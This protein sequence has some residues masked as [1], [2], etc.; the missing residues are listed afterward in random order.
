MENLKRIKNVNIIIILLYASLYLFNNYTNI[1]F[2]AYTFNYYS[3]FALLII[4]ILSF[5]INGENIKRWE[6][7]EYIPAIIALIGYIK[8]FDL[9]PIFPNNIMW[10]LSQIIGILGILFMSKYI[11]YLR[12]DD[13]NNSL[14]IQKNLSLLILTLAS[15]VHLFYILLFISNPNEMLYKNI[16]KFMCSI[17]LLYLLIVK[18]QLKNVYAIP[19]ALIIPCVLS[20]VIKRSSIIGYFHFS[21]LFSILEEYFIIILLTNVIYIIKSIDE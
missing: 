1:Q 14:Y 7:I 3:L 6:L 13:S 18:N 16:I 20:E 4:G 12:K 10:E 5:F 17:T 15:I 9:G 21:F 11:F 2:A 8:N 19:F